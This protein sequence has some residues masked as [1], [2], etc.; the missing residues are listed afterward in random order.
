MYNTRYQTKLA[1]EN[2][3]K[4]YNKKMSDQKN[5]NIMKYIDNITNN[6]NLPLEFKQLFMNVNTIDEELMGDNFN[7]Y[8]LKF[9]NDS[10]TK[11]KMSNN[12]YIDIAYKYTGLGYIYVLSYDCVLKRT[13]IRLTGG[14]E[15]NECLYNTNYYKGNIMNNRGSYFV[16]ENQLDKLY[17][18]ND[19][20]VNLKSLNI[21]KMDDTIINLLVY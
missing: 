7:F 8:S 11:Y 21:D 15:Y 20:I 10:A 1:K 18:F 16:I 12:Y 14:S 6:Y 2:V 3:K 13:F 19:G 9:I 4:Y 17:S 5:N